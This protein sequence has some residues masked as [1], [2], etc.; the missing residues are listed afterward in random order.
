MIFLCPAYD[1]TNNDN[2]YDIR[3]YYAIMKYFETMEDM[4][5]LI[6]KVNM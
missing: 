4:Y 2:E 1:S 6:I 5:K 3:D